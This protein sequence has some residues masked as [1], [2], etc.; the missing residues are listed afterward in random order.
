MSAPEAS[1]GPALGRRL[2]TVPGVLLAAL[3]Y[4]PLL[5]LALPA[6]ALVDL[7]LRTRLGL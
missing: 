5:P 2:L 6:T 4:L 1:E 3:V 7:A